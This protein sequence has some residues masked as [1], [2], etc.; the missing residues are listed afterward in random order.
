MVWRVASSINNV[1]VTS[2]D[3]LLSLE[4]Y[5]MHNEPELHGSMTGD[6]QHSDDKR[7]EGTIGAQGAGQTIGRQRQPERGET[8]AQSASRCNDVMMRHFIKGFD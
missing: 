1:K 3:L 5:F 8:I 7:R 6:A 2:G 4:N